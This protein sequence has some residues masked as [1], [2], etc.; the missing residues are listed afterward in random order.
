[1]TSPKVSRKA[2]H[3]PKVSRKASGSWHEH[4]R[5]CRV[6]YTCRHYQT[7]CPSWSHREHVRCAFG[8]HGSFNATLRGIAS[9]KFPTTSTYGEQDEIEHEVEVELGK[10][11][12]IRNQPMEAFGIYNSMAHTASERLKRNS[13]TA[14][15]YMLQI[16]TKYIPTSR[17]KAI[18]PVLF[19]CKPPSRELWT[20]RIIILGGVSNNLTRRPICH[21]MVSSLMIWCTNDA[22][23][24]F[25]FPPSGFVMPR[26]DDTTPLLVVVQPI[27]GN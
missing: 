8:Q 13:A 17:T 11:K 26:S 4:G 7:I 1:M 22:L 23:P 16:V 19:G 18:L 20:R 25:V 9:F 10:L 12:V 14:V 5:G 15:T 2:S 27:V 3:R 24:T 6:S 21:P